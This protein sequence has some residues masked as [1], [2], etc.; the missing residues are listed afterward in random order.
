M[1]RAITH[2]SSGITLAAFI[3]AIA[4][5]IYIAR[6]LEKENLIRQ[7]PEAARSALIERTLQQIHQRAARFRLTAIVVIRSG[8]TMGYGAEGGLPAIDST[9]SSRSA[10]PKTLRISSTLASGTESAE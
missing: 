2:V 7:A 10:K 8:K 3:C 1:G 5:W 4:A 6:I 9:L